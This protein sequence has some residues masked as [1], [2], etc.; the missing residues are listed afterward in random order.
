MYRINQIQIEKRLRKLSKEEIKYLISLKA[1]GIPIQYQLAANILLDSFQEAAIVYDQLSD[2]EKQ[3]F[4]AFP[5]RTLW[6]Q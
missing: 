1:S 4:D 2:A 6:K 3:F 5:I